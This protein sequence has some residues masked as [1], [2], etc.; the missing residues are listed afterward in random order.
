MSPGASRDLPEIVIRSPAGAI[1][2]PMRKKQLSYLPFFAFIGTAIAFSEFRPVVGG[3]NAVEL[4]LWL[5]LVSLVVA[6]TSR[7]LLALSKT[8][9]QHAAD[10]R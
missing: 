9:R 10:S 2:H 7:A 4:C 3:W 5:A 8:A 6:A 1:R